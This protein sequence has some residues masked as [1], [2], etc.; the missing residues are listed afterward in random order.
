MSTHLALSNRRNH[1]TQ[2]VKIAGQRTLYIKIQDDEHPAEIFLRLKGT[3]WA[4]S[5][6][7]VHES[8]GSHRRH[9]LIEY[10]GRHELAHVPLSTNAQE[11][12]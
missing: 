5:H 2:T 3:D 8:P 12:S 6:Q 11:T 9:L 4:R 10:C 1:I 7:V